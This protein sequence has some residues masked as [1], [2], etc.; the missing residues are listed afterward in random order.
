M[1]RIDFNTQNI[2]KQ[3]HDDGS[4]ELPEVVISDPALS[5]PERFGLNVEESPPI[6]FD[7]YPGLSDSQANA[8]LDREWKEQRWPFLCSEFIQAL[9]GVKMEAKQRL[10]EA[11]WRLQKA[12]DQA[13]GDYTDAKVVAELAK[14]QDVRDKSN[15]RELEITNAFKARKDPQSWPDQ[16]NWVSELMAQSSEQQVLIQW[17][18]AQHSVTAEYAPTQVKATFDI[19]DPGRKD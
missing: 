10:D 14:R 7:R 2:G 13:A 15:A 11:Q 12:L 4:Y 8:E 5:V 18:N 17:G 1:A 19:D 3:I 16:K 6:V 9:H